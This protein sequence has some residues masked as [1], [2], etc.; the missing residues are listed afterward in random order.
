LDNP[1]SEISL[2]KS[3]HGDA[4]VRDFHPTSPSLEAILVFKDALIITAPMRKVNCCGIRENRSV[5]ADRSRPFFGFHLCVFSLSEGV[6][7]DCQ[8]EWTQA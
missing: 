8:D 1:N 7:Y 2:P 4:I 5:S 6:V 3:I